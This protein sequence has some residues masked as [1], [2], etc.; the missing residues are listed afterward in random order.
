MPIKT[1]CTAAQL[2][3]TGLSIVCRM[4]S[5]DHSV[6]ECPA[7]PVIPSAHAKGYSTARLAVLCRPWASH[8]TI[9]GAGLRG[10]RLIWMGIQRLPA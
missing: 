7:S 3:P 2:P 10:I 5:S 9:V 6:S 8:V 1:D 4:L